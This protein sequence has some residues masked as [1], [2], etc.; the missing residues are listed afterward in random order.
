MDDIL[1]LFD[2][3]EARSYVIFYVSRKSL[4]IMLKRLIQMMINSLDVIRPESQMRSIFP[5]AVDKVVQSLMSLSPLYPFFS[6]L[7]S[8]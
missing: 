4:L 3:I 5:S 8:F 1:S 2:V 6:V 7:L